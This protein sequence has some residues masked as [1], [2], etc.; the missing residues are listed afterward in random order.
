[1]RYQHNLTHEHKT[2]CDMGWLIPVAA[3]EVLPGDSFLMSTS[4]LARVAPQANP[5]MHSVELRFHSWYVPARILWDPWEDWITGA[6]DT[7]EMPK[8]TVSATPGENQLF[9]YLGIPPA[10]AG[11]QISALWIR[12]YNKIWNYRYRDQELQTEVAEDSTGLQ[13]ICW[14]KDYFTTCR[15]QPQQGVEGGAQ[16][17]FA[18]DIPVKGIGLDPSNLSWVN[19]TI[20]QSDGSEVNHSVQSAGTAPA[21]LVQKGT[22]GFPNVR[23]AAG[24]VGG[25]VDLDDL[26]R[27]VAMKRF[28]EARIRFGDRYE[29]YLRWLGV[30]PSSGRLDRPEFLGGGSRRVAFSE[31]LSTAESG[32]VKVGDL[33]GHGIA[34]ARSRRWRKTFEEHGYVFTMMSARPTTNYEDGIPRKFTRFDPMDYWQKE[35]EILPWQEVM[36]REVHWSHPIDNV[37]GYQQRFDEYRHEMSHVSGSFRRGGTEADW[38]MGRQFESPPA[39]NASFVQCTPTDRI[40][41]DKSM[42]ELIVRV[43]HRLTARRFV[44]QNAMFGVNT[45]L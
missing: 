25:T 12:A 45:A 42:P 8:V 11:V 30:N 41:Q 24:T 37:F 31:V 3:L 36:G 15:P 40:Y 6:D 39:L 27:A 1:M 13:R 43:N 4:A 22:T 23:I 7:S 26:R 21:H 10:A 32:S 20:R 2:T 9:D 34:S 14:G 38:H 29:D 35:F 19:S 44:R 28:Q 16:V 5:V 18:Q 17:T 33:Y